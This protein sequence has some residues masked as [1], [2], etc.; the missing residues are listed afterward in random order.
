MLPENHCTLQVLML[1]S[2]LM[3]LETIIFLKPARSAFSGVENTHHGLYLADVKQQAL[4]KEASIS[5]KKPARTA[6]SGV[7]IIQMA[8]ILHVSRRQAAGS[9]LKKQLS[10]DQN[11]PY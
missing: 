4:V 11:P 8:F 2:R 10:G 6:F 7:E 9:R 3:V 5:F 1:S